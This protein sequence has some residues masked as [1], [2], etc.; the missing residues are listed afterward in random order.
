MEKIV[1]R[2]TNRCD[3]RTLA[4][5]AVVTEEAAKKDTLY[6]IEAVKKCGDAF[7]KLIKE[8]FSHHDYT[9]LGEH[10]SEFTLGLNKGFDSPEMDKWYEMHVTTERHHLKKH[11]PDDVNLVDVLEM[12]CDCCSAGMA[13]TGK[14]FDVDVPD[15]VLRLAVKN[16]VNMIVTSIEVLNDERKENLLNALDEIKDGYD[17]FFMSNKYDDDNSKNTHKEQFAL[18]SK[19]LNL[20]LDKGALAWIKYEYDCYY[21]NN[22]EDETGTAFEYV[23]NLILKGD[24][25]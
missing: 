2:K 4:P 3:T 24:N 21:K 5:G 23:R 10:L 20:P 6:H 13:R 14:V 17:A 9:K 12:L 7:I 19:E 16:T 1:I 8:Q 18:L 22:Y 15:D 25:Q 11:V